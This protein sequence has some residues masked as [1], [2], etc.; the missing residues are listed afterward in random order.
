MVETKVFRAAE[1]DKRACLKPVFHVGFGCERPKAEKLAKGLGEESSGRPRP[2][3][4]VLSGLSS[5][6]QPFHPR[7][8]WSSG[9]PSFFFQLRQHVHSRETHTHTFC[10]RLKKEKKISQDVHKRRYALLLLV[11]STFS[12]W[13]LRQAGATTGTLGTLLAYF[14]FLICAV[15]PQK[16]FT[17]KM[18]RIV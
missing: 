11:S 13:M 6:K 18:E 5:P 1:V 12:P 16:N 8:S 7:S 3:R 15:L 10:S 2:N 4:W 14:F 9:C 17:A